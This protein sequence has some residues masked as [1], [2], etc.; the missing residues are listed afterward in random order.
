MYIPCGHEV[1]QQGS[2]VQFP[3]CKPGTRCSTIAKLS[4]K[5][6]AY[7]SPTCLV[8]ATTNPFEAQELADAKE[9]M[10][11]AKGNS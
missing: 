7:C 5:N 10:K 11:I 8:R 2:L 3:S 1:K 4:F 6:S 9:M